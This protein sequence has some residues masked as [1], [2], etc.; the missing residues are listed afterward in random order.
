MA[1]IAGINLEDRKKISV[2][3]TAIYGIGRKNVYGILRQAKIDPVKK[4]KDL[5]TDEITKLTKVIGEQLVEGELK[6]QIGENV[7][8]LRS[9]GTY[10]GIRHNQG[11]P[12]RGQ[13][14]RSNARTRR[15]K[16]QTVGAMRKKD[17]AKLEATKK[18]G[19]DEK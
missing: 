7:K 12:V 9:I 4:I 6:R 18:G 10:K 15:G 14:T 16:R 13:R 8:R 1:R 2:G 3:L 5:K 11:L 17:M 19:K